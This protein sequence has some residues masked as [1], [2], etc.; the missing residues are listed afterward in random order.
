MSHALASTSRTKPQY[1][2][3]RRQIFAVTW[4]V[5]AG[6]YFTRQTF[7]VAKLGILEDPLLHTTLTKSTLANLDALYLAAYA[8]GQFVWGS[9]SD[10]FGPRIVLLGG[11]AMSAIAALFMGL[12]PALVFLVPLMIVQGLA[13]STGWSGTLKNIAQFFSV[14]ERGRVLGWWS[15]N[16]AFGG[17]V[18]GPFLG[19][20][21]YAVFDNW[22]IAFFTGAVVVA[23]VFVM[24]LLFQ[25]NSPTDVGLEP[26]E[27]YHS[28]EE[29]PPVEQ[30]AEA[31]AEP[32]KSMREIFL[33]VIKDRMVFTFGVSY[34]LL[35]P[36]RY[37]ILLWGPVIVA[38]R[39]PDAGF[40]EAITIPVAFG[41]AGV[42]AP[43]LI[44]RISDTMFKARRVP[45][46]VLSLG[47]LT[48]ALALFGPLTA[49]AN[50]WLMVVLLSVIGLTVYAADA[51]YGLAAV[52]F[53]TSKHAGAASGVINGCGSVGA[54]LG[55]LLPGYLGVE[56]LFYSFAAAAFISMCLLVPHWSRMPAG[57]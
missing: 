35:K 30:G 22:R 9:V 36:A 18:A 42:I 50:M 52:D 2:R 37:A 27:E 40:F 33:T 19:W 44:G 20:V 15:T 14:R 4:L 8:V 5:Y 47:A 24:V 28:G 25:R 16:Y 48:V 6:F 12:L 56:A 41:I 13:Q 10:R 1:E 23:G 11:L 26:I 34:F 3:W 29:L 51:M 53:G 39:L 46:C 43:V 45:P 38:E 54:I 7:S 55:G 31:I 21:A 49:S 17:L 57:E 32:S